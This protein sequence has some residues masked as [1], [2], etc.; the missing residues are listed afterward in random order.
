MSSRISNILFCSALLANSFLSSF[1]VSVPFR[2]SPAARNVAENNSVATNALEI[3]THMRVLKALLVLWSSNIFHAIVVFP[4]PP[5]PNIANR[6]TEWS[7]SFSVN[8]STNVGI[9]NSMYFPT[10]LSRHISFSFGSWHDLPWWSFLLLW[11][12]VAERLSDVLR[13]LFCKTSKLFLIY[14]SEYSRCLI[15]TWTK[16]QSAERWRKSLSTGW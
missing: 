12:S 2:A 8:F 10:K 14:L 15:C 1:L 11:L 7:R 16:H 5:V 6:I 4:I 13:M 9:S 3:D